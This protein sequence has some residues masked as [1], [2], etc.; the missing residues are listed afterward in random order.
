[1]GCSAMGKI[2]STIKPPN[3]GICIQTNLLVLQN[4]TYDHSQIKRTAKWLMMKT[5]RRVT[6]GPVFSLS[7]TEKKTG[8]KLRL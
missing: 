7:A 1:M 3:T 4:H 8:N 5:A 6:L 2:N